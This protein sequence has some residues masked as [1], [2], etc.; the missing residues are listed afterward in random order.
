MLIDS[1]QSHLE[2]YLISTIAL[3]NKNHRRRI[4]VKKYGWTYEYIT[5]CSESQVEKI[6]RRMQFEERCGIDLWRD[7]AN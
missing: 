2:N 4:L 5:N 6:W 1:T 3:I 7:N